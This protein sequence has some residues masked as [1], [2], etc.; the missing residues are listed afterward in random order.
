MEILG[1]PIATIYLT[2]LII[3]GALT[4]LFLFFGELFEGLG[5]ALPIPFFSP[6]LILAFIT[7]FS[8]SGYIFEALLPISSLLIIFISI[9]LSIFLV[10]LLNVFVLIPLSAAEE[11][12]AYREE[13]LKGRIG[14]VITSIPIDGYGEVVLEGKGGTISKSAVSFD[15]LPIPYGTTILVIEIESGVLSVVPHEP[16][17]K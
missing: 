11:S 4:L 10:T 1:T 8:A 6:A 13:D 2:T 12:I 16:F 7:F 9:I 3:A 14:R 5:E 15:N 17:I